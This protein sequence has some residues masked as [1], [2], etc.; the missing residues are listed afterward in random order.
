M[1]KRYPI[2]AGMV[3]LKDFGQIG[4]K[5]LVLKCFDGSWDLPKGRLDLGE[6]IHQCAVRETREEAGITSVSYPWGKTHMKLESLTFYLCKTEQDPVIRPN[7]A[8]G[9]C[10]HESAWWVDPSDAVGLLP[11]LLKPP[12]NWVM[13]IL[14]E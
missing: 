7:P 5:V 10:E 13:S 3:V 14:A 9:H 8:H 2:G 11:D 12:I 1:G 4:T 6:T